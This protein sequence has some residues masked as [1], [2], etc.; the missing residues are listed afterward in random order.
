MSGGIPYGD[1]ICLGLVV[2]VYRILYLLRHRMFPVWVRMIYDNG[3]WGSCEFEGVS[4]LTD[5]NVLY[6]VCGFLASDVVC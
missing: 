2:G 5:L 4:N 1:V 6:D 3:S